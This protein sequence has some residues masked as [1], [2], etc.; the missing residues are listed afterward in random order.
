MNLFEDWKVFEQVV[1][2]VLKLQAKKLMPVGRIHFECKVSE[3][4]TLGIDGV[5]QH[6][7]PIFGQKIVFQAKNYT[8]N[9]TSS[10]SS[11]RSPQRSN[12]RTRT[13]ASS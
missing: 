12:G 3:A 5:L 7:H 9:A 10:P 8:S 2:R 4:G 1:R 11:M 13:R 6:E